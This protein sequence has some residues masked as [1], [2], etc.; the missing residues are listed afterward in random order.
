VTWTASSTLTPLWTDVPPTVTSSYRLT[1][2]ETPPDSVTVSATPSPTTFIPTAVIMTRLVPV[3]LTSP[4]LVVTQLVANPLAP[5]PPLQVH[6]TEQT[7]P[8]PSDLF[9]WSRSEFIALIQ[10]SGRWYLRPSAQA[11]VGA[12]HEPCTIAQFYASPT[13]PREPR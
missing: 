5:P 12:F 11:S 9:G 10:V 1:A 13:P 6:A 3:V 8:R 2:T 7:T 4:L